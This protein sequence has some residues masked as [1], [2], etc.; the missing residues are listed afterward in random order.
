[1][2]ST[3]LSLAAWTSFVA[4]ALSASTGCAAG[5]M[6]GPSD[7]RDDAEQESQSLRCDGSDTG[8]HAS[9]TRCG[10]LPGAFTASSANIG[11][12]P[13]VALRDTPLYS[14]DFGPGLG[15]RLLRTL[16]KGDGF[17]I[18]STRN[19]TCSDA[20]PMRPS[21]N[22][23]VYGLTRS[24]SEA[25]WIR[26]TDVVSVGEAT[27]D[28]CADGPGSP[29]TDFQVARNAEDG[30]KPFHCTSGRKSCRSANG[31]DDGAD[32]CIGGSLA[33]FVREVDADTLHLRYAQGSTSI[34]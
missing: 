34:G 27:Q 18:Q 5:G 1:M 8:Y 10:D 12:Y 6:D 22:G 25:G 30:C 4:I 24:G 14:G 7:P 32:D 33:D 26:L 29:G 3:S 11:Y 2:R 15:G 16:S 28:T 9:A 21:V 23:F 31:E 19:P 13:V 20:P 17:A